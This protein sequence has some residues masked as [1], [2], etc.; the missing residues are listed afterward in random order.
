MP[1]KQETRG[2]SSGQGFRRGFLGRGFLLSLLLHVNGLSLVGM[3][4]WTMAEKE[5]AQR[6]DEVDVAFEE[7]S[8]ADL[9]KDLPP[10]DAPAPDSLDVPPAPK[11]DKRKQKLAEALEKPKQPS[12]P[13][14]EIVVPPLPPMPEQPPP[15][16]EK[17]S[18]HEKMVDL[19]TD[20][21]VEAPADAKFLA[22]KNS[23]ADEETRARDTNL[24]KAQK[25]DAPA[26]SP[27]NREDT[28]PGGD[29]EKIAE[30]EDVKS[31]LGRKA[32]DVTPHVQP[33]QIQAERRPE[34]K[35]P[36]ALRDPAP[37][38]HEL[39]P[40]TADPSLPRADDGELARPDRNVR[41]PKTDPTAAANG[42]QIKLA[43]SAQD[44]EYMFG[45]EAEAERRLAQKQRST[46]LG[47]G[48]QKRARVL[49][50]LENFIPEIRE[51]NVTSLNARA[52]PFA[53]FIARMHRNIHKLWGFGALE[54]WDDL[55][56][57]SP[58]NN[59]N[60]LTTLDIVLERD[61]T[62]GKVTMVRS[63]G[64]LPYDAA[65]ID[66]V[67]SAGPYP[68]P[69]RG[70]RSPNGKIYIRWR[71]Y[72]DD[73]QCATSGVDHAIL[74]NAPAGGD[75]GDGDGHDHDH[76]SGGAAAPAPGVNGGGPRRLQ[77]LDRAKHRAGL[78]R[79]DQEVATAEDA[80]VGSQQSAQE[81]ASAATR[82][83]DPAARVVAERWFGALAAGRA[84]TMLEMAVLPFRTSGKEVARRD[85][86]E[87]MLNDLARETRGAGGGGPSR[88]EI[89]TTASL[90]GTIGKLPPNVDDGSG[91]Q[92][93]A[94]AT[95]GGHDV[96]IL[97]LGQRG[98][99]WR[100][101]GLVRR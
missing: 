40:E 30:L 53:A 26:S 13:E 34:N 61:G 82:S 38:A 67:Y 75:H 79:L 52:A 17:R 64:Y 43:L 74:D 59:P 2:R 18:G 36:L 81:S 28:A 22:E 70:M 87:A 78:E 1:P 69:P 97:I 44:Y 45:A 5:I 99:Q 48:E 25:G 49:A 8:A 3:L 92:L 57:S 58:F 98:G 63:S 68:D 46:K 23:R 11:V 29:K 66:T 37:R 93:Y 88:L 94:L 35:S 12:Q 84:R 55:P 71:F 62:V 76:E 96:L 65:A 32:P 54:D 20:R 15:P 19:E 100:P 42:K 4:I 86:L 47:R 9:P 6:P 56:G 24:E 89:H 91:E 16:P 95:S 90:R 33:E 10:L 50:A 85:A 72:R 80:A 41:G 21:E 14:P 31:E 77:R 73:R 60:L 27:S 39:T 83:S 51:G 101:V 7:I